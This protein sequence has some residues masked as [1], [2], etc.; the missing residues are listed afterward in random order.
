LQISNRRRSHFGIKLRLRLAPLEFGELPKSQE[1]V[2]IDVC[3]VLLREQI[4]EQPSP[5]F[6]RTIERCRFIVERFLNTPPPRSSACAR[7]ACSI[8]LRRALS[9]IRAFFAALKNH[10]VLKVRLHRFI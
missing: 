4:G 10:A 3:A 1:L 8:A 7:A 6:A 9:E 5:A 2:V